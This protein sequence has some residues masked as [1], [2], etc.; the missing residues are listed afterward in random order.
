MKKEIR[1]NLAPLPA[2]PYSQGLQVGNRIYVAGQVGIGAKT[3]N[4]SESIEDQTRQVLINISNI[5]KAAGATINDVVKVTAH[6][7]NMNDFDAYN[8]VYAE[9]FSGPY[10]VR[11]TLGSDLG[12][13]KVKI[14]A[15]AEME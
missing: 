13:F 6:L 10:P 9:F 5:L 1:T 2:G 7:S 11:I 3:G 8:K 12:E 15:I 14:E 4:L